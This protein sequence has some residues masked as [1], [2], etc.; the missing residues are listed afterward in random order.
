M[1]T[2]DLWRWYSIDTLLNECSV[3]AGMRIWLKAGNIIHVNMFHIIN[4]FRRLRHGNPTKILLNLCVSLTGL[5]IVLYITE[6]IA[7]DRHVGCTASSILRYYF[8]MTSLMWNGV[9]GVN[10]YILL[11]KVM[12]AHVHRFVLK[13]AVVAWGKWMASRVKQKI[14]QRHILLSERSNVE[15]RGILNCWKK[16]CSSL[17]LAVSISIPP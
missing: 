6:F 11:V 1:F 10:M 5:L 12:N 7:G 15:N 9:E 13:A 16:S 14:E 4:T 3:F 2:H 8:I 17:E